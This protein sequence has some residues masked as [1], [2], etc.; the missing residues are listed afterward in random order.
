L[1]ALKNG[2]SHKNEL[3]TVDLG[4]N[5]I[6]DDGILALAQGLKTHVRLHMLFLDNNAITA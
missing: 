1:E 4:E 3:R 6:K 5:G 2:I